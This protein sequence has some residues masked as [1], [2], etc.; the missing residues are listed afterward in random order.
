MASITVKTN[1]KEVTDAIMEKIKK[2]S[3][4]E[5][6]LRPIALGVID[7][8]TTR[9]HVDG[10]RS[11]GKQIG[12]YSNGYLRLREKMNRGSDRK[13]IV[14]L[15]RQLE[16]DWSV[17]ATPKGYG[18]G[19]NNPHNLEKLRWVEGQKGEVSSL[20][21]GETKYVGDVANDLVKQALK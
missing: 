3:D 2:A 4:K 19:F 14:S 11:D 13:I 10:K 5:Y 18:V 9:I 1:I 15:T 6:L 7:K 8:M 21:K 17:I 20:T 12:R 16:N